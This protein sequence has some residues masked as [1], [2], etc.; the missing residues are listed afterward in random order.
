MIGAHRISSGPWIGVARVRRQVSLS[1]NYSIVHTKHLYSELGKTSVARGRRSL[2][3]SNLSKV[4]ASSAVWTL[5]PVGEV[6]E[7]K[8]TWTKDNGS[9]CF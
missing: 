4:V 3:F 1:S 2:S 6:R 8:L 9:E 5:H 7:L